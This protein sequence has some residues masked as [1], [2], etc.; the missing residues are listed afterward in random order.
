[1]ITPGARFLSPDHVGNV[2]FV[3][4]HHYRVATEGC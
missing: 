4:N 2:E 1:L 3:N